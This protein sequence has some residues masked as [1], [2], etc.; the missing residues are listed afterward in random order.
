M[1]ARKSDER[2][3]AR[4]YPMKWD[5]FQKEGRHKL[6]NYVGDH[7]PDALINMLVDI[8]LLYQFLLQIDLV[9]PY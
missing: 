5:E 7:A 2:N 8:L 3:T 4:V 1:G 6:L 9:N